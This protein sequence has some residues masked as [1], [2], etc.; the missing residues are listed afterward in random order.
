MQYDAI[1]QRDVMQHNN[2]EDN[3]LSNIM[4]LNIIQHEVT[5]QYADV[6]LMITEGRDEI[7]KWLR[8]QVVGRHKRPSSDNQT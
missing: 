4:S 6:R 1:M 7:G 8:Q 5:N 2:M 3:L